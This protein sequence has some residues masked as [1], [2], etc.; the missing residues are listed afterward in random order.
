VSLIAANEGEGG[1]LLWVG[2]ERHQNV[3]LTVQLEHQ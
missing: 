2:L 3:S 1:D